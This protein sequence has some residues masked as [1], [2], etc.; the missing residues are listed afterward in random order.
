MKGKGKYLYKGENMSK[1]IDLTGQS[2]G[3]WQVIKRA[4]NRSGGRAY[5]LCKC[6]AC[7]KEKE[8]AS[9]HLRAGRSTNCG[10]IRMEKMRQASIKN[11]VGKDFGFLHVERMATKEEKPRQDRDGIY[12]VCTCKKCGRKNVIVFGDYLRKGETQSCGC[13]NSKNESLICQMLDNANIKYS[14]QKTFSNL[15]SNK[16]CDKLIF[17]LAIYN[18]DILIYLIEYDGIQHF[19]KGHFQN[20]FETTHKNDLIKNK[21]CFDNN[22][23]LIRIPFDAKYDLNDLKLETTR[24]LLTPENEEEYYKTRIKE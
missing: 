9:S 1:L 7:G 12:W 2:F 22:I 15:F 10:C 6:T 4:P 13:L 20:T 14:Q 23:P 5:W 16:V 17:D 3:Y 21:Y 24:F 11:E 18:K 8:V 19:E